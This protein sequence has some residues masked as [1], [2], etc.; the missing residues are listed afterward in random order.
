MRMFHFEWNHAGDRITLS[1]ECL[2]VLGL[3]EPATPRTGTDYLAH[4]HPEDRGDYRAII[5]ALTPAQSGYCAQ[6]RVVTGNGREKHLEERGLGRFDD[7]GHLQARVGI[8]AERAF[9]S[10]A[11]P[12]AGSAPGGADDFLR[13]ILDASLNG[14]YVHDLEKGRNTF[15]NAR[16]TSL[17]GY[18][19]DR[20]NAMD[21]SAF[22][23]LF[24]PEDLPAVL[25]HLTM[26]REVTDDR[27]LEI[28]Y[29]F[30]RSDG[31]WI[32]C[33]SS[34]SV[35]ERDSDGSVRSIIGTFIDITSRKQATADLEVSESRARS[36]LAEIEHIYSTAPIGL[37]VL[38]RGLRFVRINDR[39]AKING[40]KRSGIEE[41]G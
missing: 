17:T 36:H 2:N 15:I 21:T 8:V 10:A 4:I 31:E 16:Y 34:D 25:A 12:A 39:L 14:I 6:Y 9:Q 13:K 41:T 5:G 40:W 24:H 35:F 30:R 3:S 18:T 20:L 23:D 26:L 37:C 33:L 11:Q 29:R 19:L 27:S 38:D 22:L 1:P 32:W 28:E 7:R